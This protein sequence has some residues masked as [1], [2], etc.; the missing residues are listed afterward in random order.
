MT[1]MHIISPMVIVYPPEGTIGFRS[2]VYIDQEKEEVLWR[3]KNE[4]GKRRVTGYEIV[5]RIPVELLED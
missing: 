1:G 4:D 3:V 5:E 2:G